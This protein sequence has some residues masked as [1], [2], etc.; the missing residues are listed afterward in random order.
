MP[1][2]HDGRDVEILAVRPVD[3]PQL[4]AFIRTMAAF[5]RLNVSATEASLHD[6]LFGEPPAAQASLISVGGK[7]AGY[8]IYYFTFTSMRGSRALWLEDLYLEPDFR[9]QGIGRA[10]MAHLAGLA[11]E[12]KCARFEWIV[13]DWNTNAVKFYERLG[14]EV[15]PD[16]RICRVEGARLHQLAGTAAGPGDAR[17]L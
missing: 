1:R 15:L 16:W 14:A 3:I 7:A 6:A 13:L 4:L 8:L 5:E 2:T 9:G 10:L 12:R 17:P 11:V